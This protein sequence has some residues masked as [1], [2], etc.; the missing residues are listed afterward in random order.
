[1]GFNRSILE[2]LPISKSEGFLASR[3]TLPTVTTTNAA[4]PVPERREWQ[5]QG[6]IPSHSGDL[7]PMRLCP[8]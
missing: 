2:A 6:A 4:S 1:A 7:K 3:T 8:A 5:N